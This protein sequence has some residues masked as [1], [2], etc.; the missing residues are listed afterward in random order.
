MLRR[1]IFPSGSVVASAV[2]LGACLDNGPS[3]DE[4]DFWAGI[5]PVQVASGPAR[6]GPW[7][8]NNSDFD[9]VD[10]ATVAVTSDGHVGVAWVDQRQQEVYFQM[11]TPAGR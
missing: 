7:R 11:Y 9:Y 2:L 8:M 1:G 4:T 3:A 10:D 5:K 6:L